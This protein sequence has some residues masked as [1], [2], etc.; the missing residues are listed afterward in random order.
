MEEDLRVL[1][2]FRDLSMYGCLNEK[3]KSRDTE[4][5]TGEMSAGGRTDG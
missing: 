2:S 4:G 5:I 3:R 1:F